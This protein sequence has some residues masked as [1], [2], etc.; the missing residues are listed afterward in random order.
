MNQWIIIALSLGNSQSDCIICL[1]GHEDSLFWNYFLIYL[2]TWVWVHREETLSWT[3]WNILLI[4][5]DYAYLVILLHQKLVLCLLHLLVL[6]LSFPKGKHSPKCFLGTSSFRKKTPE[7]FLSTSS[8]YFDII[9]N[10]E[11]SYKD[12][13]RNFHI[14]LSRFTVYTLLHSLYHSLSVYYI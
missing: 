2:W 12:S 7:C 14:P 8:F 5:V 11:K 9:S 6:F 10:L 1:Q 4:L 3:K 13:I